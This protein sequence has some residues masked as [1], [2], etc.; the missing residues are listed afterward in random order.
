MNF[1]MY[2]VA[3]LEIA[4][5]IYGYYLGQGWRFMMVNILVGCANIVYAGSRV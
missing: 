5:G 4:A 1:L 3:I 2:A